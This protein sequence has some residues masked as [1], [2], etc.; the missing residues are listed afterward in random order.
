M[1]EQI[2]TVCR[3]VYLPGIVSNSVGDNQVSDPVAEVVVYDLVKYLLGYLNLRSL[4]FNNHHRFAGAVMNQDICP[5]EHRVKPEANLN[6][7]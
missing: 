5:A 7:N 4:A 2:K 1:I 6:A 3:G